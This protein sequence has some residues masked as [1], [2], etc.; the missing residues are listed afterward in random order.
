MVTKTFRC[1]FSMSVI[2][3][4]TALILSGHVCLIDD[5]SLGYVQFD[6]SNPD[7]QV[8]MIYWVVWCVY[9]PELCRLKAPPSRTVV[10]AS[11]MTA[12]TTITVH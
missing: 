3:T 4:V 12:T 6:T 7:K 9:H 10:Q 5:V 11:C 2:G 8:Q 1:C